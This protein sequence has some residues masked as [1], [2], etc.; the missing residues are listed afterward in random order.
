MHIHPYLHTRTHTRPVSLLVRGLQSQDS[1]ARPWVKDLGEEWL[2]DCDLFEDLE[3]GEVWGRR[4]PLEG[5]LAHWTSPDPEAGKIQRR[6]EDLGGK[7]GGH[8]A[9]A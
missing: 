1:G 5:T 4:Q 9:R 7:G 3:Y 2:P 8:A 6:G